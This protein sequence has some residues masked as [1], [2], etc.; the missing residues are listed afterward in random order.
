[1]PKEKGSFLPLVH[2]FEAFQK[3][4]KRFSAQEPALGVPAF[5]KTDRIEPKIMALVI[6]ILA[7]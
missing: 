6:L 7:D 3:A 4:F 5:M 1:L 2:Y